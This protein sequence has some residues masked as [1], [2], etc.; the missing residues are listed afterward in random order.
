MP[1]YG[2]VL[3][4]LTNP[5]DALPMAAVVSWA[6]ENE[7]GKL[8]ALQHPNHGVSRSVIVNAGDHQ[9]SLAA[10]DKLIKLF[11]IDKLAKKF[12]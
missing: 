12:D 8:V 9:Q 3:A 2:S 1:V 6:D 7:V 11:A 10:L 4:V 5:Q